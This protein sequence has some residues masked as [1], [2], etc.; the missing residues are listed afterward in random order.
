MTTSLSA[1]GSMR[2]L[3]FLMQHLD[4]ARFELV[5]ASMAAPPPGD[6]LPREIPIHVIGEQPTTA[7]HVETGIPSEFSTESPQDVAWVQLFVDQIATVVRSTAPDAVFCAP[8]WIAPA[9]AAACH[10]TGSPALIARFGAAA[11]K[12]FPDDGSNSVYRALALENLRHIDRVVAVSS[13]I[14]KDLIYEFRIDAARVAHLQNVVD[15]SEIA[16]LAAVPLDDP[17]FDYG[18]PSV[19]F[20]GRLVRVKGL[21]YLLRAVAE[22]IATTPM[23]LVLIGKGSQEGY[24]RALAKHLGIDEHVRFAGEQQNPFRYLHRATAFVLSSTSE[25]MPNVLLEAMASGC[26]VIATDIGGG[27]TRDILSDGEC[28]LIVPPAD[29]RALAGAIKTMLEDEELRTELSRRGLE[30]TADFDLPKMVTAYDHLISTVASGR[31]AALECCEVGE[32][33]G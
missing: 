31:R 4:P 24:L 12:A 32:S 8:E 3:L 28:G 17:V 27:I 10:A 6:E 20:V 33:D 1:G 15:V 16:R 19:V 22:V 5:V 18:V 14:E 29:A 26:P 25:G 2:F 13:A 9:A 23:R 30:R 21:E 11:S 7:T